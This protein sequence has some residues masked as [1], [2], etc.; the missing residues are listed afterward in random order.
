VKFGVKKLTRNI[1]LSRIV[2]TYF[3]IFNRV[4]MANECDKLTDGRTERPLAIARL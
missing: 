1:A 4:G 2:R 3:D